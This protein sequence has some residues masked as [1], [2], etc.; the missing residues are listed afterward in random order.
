VFHD[1]LFRLKVLVGRSKTRCL[2]PRLF[3]F[4]AL[5]FWTPTRFLRI[6]FPVDIGRRGRTGGAARRFGPFS[7]SQKRFALGI[8]S[9][10]WAPFHV[11]LGGF[12]VPI[13]PV[14]DFS[15]ARFRCLGDVFFATSPDGF[16]SR[17]LG[18][19]LCFCLPEISPD[20]SVGRP[21]LFSCG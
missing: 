7:C 10:G 21:W 14:V 13:K 15:V 19:R 16:F 12:G 2:C 18:D 6:L 5:F 20:V 3:F 9:S 11:H 17:F 4:M 1:V 8:S